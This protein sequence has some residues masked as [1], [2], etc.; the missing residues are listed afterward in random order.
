MQRKATCNIYSTRLNVGHVP[1]YAKIDD[2]FKS[3]GLSKECACALK[4]PYRKTKFPLKI[5]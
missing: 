1:D 3:T 4:I 2:V 5:F